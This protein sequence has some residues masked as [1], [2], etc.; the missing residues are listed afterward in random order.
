[1]NYECP[2]CASSPMTGHVIRNPYA[3]TGSPVYDK[4]PACDGAGFIPEAVVSS[5][6][7]FARTPTRADEILKNLRWS[8]D[9]FSFNMHGMY[10][11]VE[12]TDGYIHT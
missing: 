3:N 10:V 9:H 12:K 8:S 5:I 2:R 7:N 6:T 4:C 11:G 1:M